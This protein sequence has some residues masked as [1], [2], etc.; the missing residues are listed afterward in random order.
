MKTG[1]KNSRVKH[2]F[3]MH[4]AFIHPRS[5]FLVRVGGGGVNPWTLRKKEEKNP[6]KWR[7]FSLKIGG[8][9]IGKF[10]FRL[11]KKEKKSGMDH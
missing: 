4:E 3:C 7:K 11:L 5:V 10:H 8:K 1:R 9:K 6:Y 2:M